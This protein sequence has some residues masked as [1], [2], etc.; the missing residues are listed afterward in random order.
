MQGLA[1]VFEDR[2]DFGQKDLE[3][4][5]VENVAGDVENGRCLLVEMEMPVWQRLKAVKVGAFGWRVEDGMLI[6]RFLKYSA[7]V[8][9]ESVHELGEERRSVL[10]F[11]TRQPLVEGVGF[12]LEVSALLAA[13]ALRERFLFRRVVPA[14]SVGGS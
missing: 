13:S 8:F 11:E 7:V 2:Y 14:R 1:L 9:R 5:N 6:Q 10:E 12:I 4:F 3:L